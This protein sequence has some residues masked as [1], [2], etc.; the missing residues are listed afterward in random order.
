MLKLRDIMSK[1]VLSV[2]PE[3]TLRDVVELLAT[4]HVGGVPVIAGN[5]VVGVISVRDIVDF[6]AAAPHVAADEREKEAWESESTIEWDE[7]GPSS[8][9]ADL[10]DGARVDLMDRF[11][12]RDRET[13]VLTNH[14]VREAMTVGAY[15]LPPSASVREAARYM[16]DKGIH[17]VLV[18]EGERLE[19]I[20]S[21]MDIVRA[22][23]EGRL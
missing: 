15:R 7:E 19:G 23:A 3:D 20:V 2:G 22:V 12:D 14:L 5:R 1:D 13:D 4:K 21:T 18:T 16:I 9:Y 8:Y 11:R 10:W 17:R 6:E